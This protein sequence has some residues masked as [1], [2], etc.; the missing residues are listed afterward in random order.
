L[1]RARK[2]HR[3]YR[4]PC[5]ATSLHA[6]INEYA[7]P[8]EEANARFVQFDKLFILPAI[9]TRTYMVNCS[10][11]LAWLGLAWL[12][13]A[14]SA[15]AGVITTTTIMKDNENFDDN[16][17]DDNDYDDNENA[18]PKPNANRD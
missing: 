3:T 13:L 1:I 18:T 16:D 6:A 4:S 7:E 2:S 10:I 11:G 14:C 17:N 15:F 8:V 9:R 12:G 5:A